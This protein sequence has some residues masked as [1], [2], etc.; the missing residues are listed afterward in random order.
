MPIPLSENPYV[1][2]VEK[3]YHFKPHIFSP[4]I[5]NKY[6]IINIL[7]KCVQPNHSV[8]FNSVLG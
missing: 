5:K 2:S 4:D 1:R 3:P 7:P 8:C 6:N